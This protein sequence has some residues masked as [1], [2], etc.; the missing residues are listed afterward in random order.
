MAIDFSFLEGA[1]QN[2]NTPIQT[3]TANVTI[4]VDADSLLLCDG[5]YIDQPFNAGVL[6]KIQLPTGQ[7]LLEF[8]C[9]ENPDVKVEKV[10]DF[11]E[12]GKSYLMIVNELK[13]AVAEETD[14]C[15]IPE[16]VEAL[17]SMFEFHKYYKGESKV[18][19]PS[20]LKKIGGAAIF[21]DERYSD[22]EALRG[23]MKTMIEW[24]AD[25]EEVSNLEKKMEKLEEK[26]IKILHIDMSRCTKLEIIGKSTFAGCN[27]LSK[28]TLP[29]SLREI[30]GKAFAN[31]DSL[32]EIVIPQ[33][34]NI[35]GRG[36][37]RGC[38]KLKKVHF[39][40]P[41]SLREIRAY[42][43]SNCKSLKEIFISENTHVEQHAFEERVK[44]KKV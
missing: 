10:V 21:V 40:D 12:A 29:N 23:E 31:C 8:L 39:E 1:A 14:T 9:V 16:G 19:L 35:I 13:A 17:E 3:D 7:H 27:Y 4:R 11:A 2:E 15:V 25:Y 22:R 43:F 6:T 41:Y 34:I 32:Q 24:G 30:H 38:S 36:A 18:R 37:F 5:D 28:V 26:I 33:N 42:A 20:T 44:L